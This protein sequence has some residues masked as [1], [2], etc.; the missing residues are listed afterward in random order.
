MAVEYLV[1]IPKWILYGSWSQK[2]NENQGE[3][4]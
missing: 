2:G 3:K 1:E 4:N